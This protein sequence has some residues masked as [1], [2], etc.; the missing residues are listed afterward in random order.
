[1]EAPHFQ[2]MVNEQR[3][4]MY[5]GFLGD[6]TLLD[7]N[8]KSVDWKSDHMLM[9]SYYMKFRKSTGKELNL[10]CTDLWVRVQGTWYHLID[11]PFYFHKDKVE[12][13]AGRVPERGK[14]KAVGGV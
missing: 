1:M 11:D 10:F 5:V 7:M 6:D 12:K 8:M 9:V 14:A 3:Y 4:A 13:V 2:E